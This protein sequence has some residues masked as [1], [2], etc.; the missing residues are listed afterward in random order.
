MIAPTVHAEVGRAWAFRNTRFN[1]GWKFLKSDAVGAEATEFDDHSWRDIQL[2]HDWSIEGPF[3]QKW[4]SGTGYLPG[5]I[6]WYRK[7]FSLTSAQAGRRISIR[8]DGV[9]K[10]SKVWCNGQLLGERPNGYV[11]F[12]YDLTPYLRPMG[13]TNVIAVRVDHSDFADSRWYP[14]SGINRDVWLINTGDVH[15]PT[16]GTF[17][18]TPQVDAHRAVV[19]V[20]TSVKNDGTEPA[21]VTLVSTI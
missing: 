2:P 12:E 17:V 5:G 10:N 18:T 16:N 6:G 20:R 13:Q 14:G 11:S 1:D 7:T 21:K 19:D 8:F 15:V 9:Y 4:A 3:D